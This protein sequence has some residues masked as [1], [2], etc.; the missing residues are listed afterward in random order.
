MVDLPGA[1]DHA[2]NIL[3]TNIPS[4]MLLPM[5][6]VSIIRRHTKFVLVLAIT[7]T[8]FSFVPMT[9]RAEMPPSAYLSFQQNA[10]EALE[11]EIT[12]VQQSRLETKEMVITSVVLAAQVLKV[13]RSATRLKAGTVITIKY[14][15]R[16]SKIPGW[17]GPSAIPILHKGDQCPAYLRLMNENPPVYEAAAGGYTF[18]TVKE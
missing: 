4:W 3:D 2:A 9:A 13:K 10:T 6:L 18:R 17:V 7:F 1:S 5:K 8:A 14:D 16:E 15:H 12:S 11:V